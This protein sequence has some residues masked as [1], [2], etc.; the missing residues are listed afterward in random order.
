M[1]SILTLIIVALGL[2]SNAS[3]QQVFLPINSNSLKTPAGNLIVQEERGVTCE[4]LD[5]CSVIRLGT[6]PIE[7]DWSVSLVGAYPSVGSPEF[8]SYS[9]HGG[10]NC[11]LPSLRI[12]DVQTDPAFELGSLFLD[13]SLPP[14]TILPLASNR[15]EI[16]GY[17]LERNNLGDPVPTPYL[18]DRN[19]KLV[20]AKPGP[21]TA[22]LSQYFN[23]YP[24]DFLS[25]SK[26]REPL[27]KIVGDNSFKEFR[28]HIDVAG[29]MAVLSYRWLIGR[30]CRAHSCGSSEG[31]FAIDIRTGSILAMQFDIDVSGAPPPD[32]TVE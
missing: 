10:G 12:I 1:R 4:P 26:A 23:K 14:P 24:H 21:G 15:F 13:S 3:A 22:D 6:R 29:P 19:R 27:V 8:V 20:W 31:Y 18:Y 11:C 16:S 30:G 25:D 32:Q 9:T 17:E 5:K 28:D 2:I 7:R